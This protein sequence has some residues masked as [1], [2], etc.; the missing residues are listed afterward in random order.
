M[1]FNP[2][3]SVDSDSPLGYPCPHDPEA[4]VTGVALIW[5]GVVMILGGIAAWW[6][7]DL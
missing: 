4:E 5:F 6:I 2:I 1:I 3:E 7:I